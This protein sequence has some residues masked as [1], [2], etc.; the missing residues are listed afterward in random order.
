M[1]LEKT[2]FYGNQL[3]QTISFIVSIYLIF[4]IQTWKTGHKEQYIVQTK[5]TEFHENTPTDK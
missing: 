4:S 2:D 5:T 3:E 1:I